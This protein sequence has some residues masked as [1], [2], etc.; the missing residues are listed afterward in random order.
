MGARVPITEEVLQTAA[1]NFEDGY[2]VLKLILEQ[3]P[4]TH[5][6]E[7]VLAKVIASN[8]DTA[9]IQFLLEKRGPDAPF[10]DKVLLSAIGNTSHG[11]AIMRLLIKKRKQNVH[12]CLS[13]G[14]LSTIAASGNYRILRL[15]ERTFSVVI[16]DEWLQLARLY[17]AA[18]ESNSPVLNEL[19]SQGIPLDTRNAR[20]ETPLWRAASRNHQSVIRTLLQTGLVDVNAVSDS[21]DSPLISAARAGY[22]S[23]VCLLLEAGADPNVANENGNTAYS[24]A[25]MRSFFGTMKA[26]ER[27][28]D[29]ST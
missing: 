7:Q 15:F 17:R 24:M 26:L 8:R 18:S 2:R 4:D 9:I 14:L 25:E 5:I 19:V 23:A 16:K 20:G 1:S 12:D 29:C 3:R 27:H 10:T 11:Y 13:D 28:L 22:T 6:T 21:G